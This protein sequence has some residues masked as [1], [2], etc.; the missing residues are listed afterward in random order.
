MGL[1][2]LMRQMSVC[3]TRAIQCAQRVE[4]SHHASPKTV[5]AFSITI[6]ARSGA[7]PPNH[8]VEVSDRGIRAAVWTFLENA[9]QMGA[10][11][12]APFMPN[13]ARVG[14]VIDALAAACHLDSKIEPPAWLDEEAILPPANE[15]FPIANGLLHLPTGWVP[16]PRRR[17]ILVS[18]PPM[19][20]L[21]R[22]LPEPAHFLA[23]LDDLFGTDLESEELYKIG[24]ATCCRPIRRNR[25]C[26]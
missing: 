13:S 10:K 1:V 16:I 24:S 8:Y 18:T 19:S 15:L 3:W 25:R 14:N 4:L 17:D 11:G 22:T 5:S 12:P 9:Y 21:I 2:N 6:A 26:C 7:V 23:F 20:C